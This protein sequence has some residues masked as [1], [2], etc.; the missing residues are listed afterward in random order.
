MNCPAKRAKRAFLAEDD[1][2]DCRMITQ[3]RTKNIAVAGIGNTP[4]HL[5]PIGCQCLPS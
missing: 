2:F 4:Y 3:H 5:C 1:N